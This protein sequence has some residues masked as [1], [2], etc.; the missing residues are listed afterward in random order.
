[1]IVKIP[2]R[3]WTGKAD[4]EIE[5]EASVEVK[6]RLRAAV[7]TAVRTRADLRDAVLTGAVLTRAVLTGAVLTVAVLTRAD[8]R[9]IPKIENIDAKI[10]SAI[11][12]SKAKGKAGLD[13]S[14]WHTCAST[15]CRAGWAVVLAGE[16]GN[17]LEEKVGEHLA[18]LLIYRESRPGMRIP[19][20]FASDEKAMED[21]R[22]C[23]ARQASQA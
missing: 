11:E 7:E 14:T 16:E 18:G 9:G 2:F 12:A 19:D 3:A 10:L 8:L 22:E 1:M 5:V 23:A 21:L 17:A 15:H 6:F 4:L 13:M 20:F